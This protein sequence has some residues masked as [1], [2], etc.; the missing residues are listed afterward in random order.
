MRKNASRPDAAN[1]EWSAEEVRRA[2]PL[3][4]VLPKDTA[5]ALRRYRG[6]RGP[7]T[8]KASEKT[9]KVDDAGSRRR[10]LKRAIR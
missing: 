8:L 2:Q 6:R 10:R 1:P 4:D 5:E 7:Q 9:R 3:M